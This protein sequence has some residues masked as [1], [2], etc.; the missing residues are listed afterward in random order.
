MLRARL[1]AR[2]SPG[3][4][5][6]V[7][8]AAA[9]AQPIIES[10]N[11]SS[12]PRSGRVVLEGSGFGAR[13]ESSAVEFD[14]LDAI[15]TT[16]TDGRIVAYVPEGAA[17][18]GNAVRVRAGGEPSNEVVLDVTVRQ[19]DGRMRWTF[20]S[21]G[22]NQWFRP[23]LAP[24]GTVYLHTSGGHVYALSPDGALLWAA[25]ASWYPYIPPAAGPDGTL[26]C[27]S[28]QTI[29]AISPQGEVS[30]T[31]EDASA[32]GLQNAITVG[33]DGHLYGAFD[34]G[35]GAVSL[36]T[37]GSLR[38][39]NTGTPTLF[40]YGSLG[41]RTVF[42]P[43]QPDGPIDQVYIGMNL[44]SDNH[45]Y[46]FDLDGN[47][48]WAAPVGPTSRGAEPAIGADGR[49]YTPDFIAAGPGWVIQA[50]N[51]DDGSI[52]WTYDAD[53]NSGCGDIVVGPNDALYYVRDLGHLESLDPHTRTLRWH[54][55]TGNVLGR[56]E[57]TPDGST[58][59]VHGTPNFGEPG[60]IWAH[61]AATG[62]M[63]WEV[64]LP[65]ETYPGTRHLATDWAR[66]TPD[67]RTAYFS[68]TTVAGPDDDPHAIFFA[69]DLTDGCVA[70]FNGD[71]AVN[72]VDVLAFLNAWVAE[73]PRADINDDGSVN[74]QDVLAFLNL[75][76]AGC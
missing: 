43:S 31:Y 64:P 45:L 54:N 20:E 2:C 16:W 61:D 14:K 23:A 58:L 19:S 21:D 66:I 70:D 51:P 10:V 57:I 22:M 67:G 6:A 59:L 25:S 12:L 24:D 18:G 4:A 56:P 32:Q 65:G 26:Y 8:A 42:G 46:A 74:T 40:D 3:F 60:F 27:G 73:D 34:Y 39:N 36:D 30:W 47:Q 52:A 1:N 28:I 7:C 33:P 76:N 71:G 38:W 9:G 15:V 44:R 75:W 17:L 68:G 72:T 50:L 48:R 11:N 41:K 69:I 63:L 55:N 37:A 5:V 35:P 13:S 29:F 62:A 49:L 53:F